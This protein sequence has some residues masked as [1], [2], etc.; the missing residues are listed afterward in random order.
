VRLRATLEQ[1]HEKRDGKRHFVRGIVRNE[2]GKL[3]VRKSGS[4]SSGVL[5]SMLVANCLVIIPEDVSLAK[6]GTEVEIELLRE[7]LQV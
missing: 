5:T 3:L 2:N 1:D 7:S 4:Q 6:A